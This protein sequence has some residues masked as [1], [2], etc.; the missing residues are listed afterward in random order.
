MIKNRISEKIEMIPIIYKI[1]SKN[2][3]IKKENFKSF[4]YGENIKQY[5]RVFDGDK[6]KPIIFFI[7]GG[8]WWH[9]S[10]KTSSC[11]GK[12]FNEL[13]YTTVL[14]AYRLAPIYKYPTQIN[15]IFMAIK[16]YLSR[17]HYVLK[18]DGLLIEEGDNSTEKNIIV[19]GFSAGG[20][21]AV[22]LVFNNEKQKEFKINRSV[23]KGL[24]TLSG[25]L[26]FEKCTS[27][28]SINL[29]GNY[30]GEDYLMRDANPI[31]LLDKT[32]DIPILS[33]HGGK[34]PLI[35]LENSIS[36]ISK[37]NSL[38]GNA[39]LEVL[40]NKYHSDIVSLIISKGE[41]ES[42]IILDFIE[43]IWKK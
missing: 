25:V 16:D 17:E 11:I 4:K 33:L 24:I 20:E 31:R 1:F 35:D 37:I 18:E 38:G 19:M 23:F 6:D 22:N 41:K 12:F 2:I 27:K 40:E 10:P 14:P 13:G 30:I 9:G 3:K 43:D 32:Y 39:K 42:R 21:L 26:D 29:I 28:H 8:G 7:H 36:F 15:D 5:Y 34:D